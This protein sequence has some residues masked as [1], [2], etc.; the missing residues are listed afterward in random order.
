LN[1]SNGIT[2]CPQGFKEHQKYLMDECDDCSKP[3][4][5]TSIQIENGKEL[6]DTLHRIYT[7][8]SNTLTS[9]LEIGKLWKDIHEKN[10]WKSCGNEEVKT[11]RQFCEKECMRSHATVYNFINLFEKFSPHAEGVAVEQTR[12]VKALPFVTNEDTAKDWVSKAT[13]LNSEDYDSEIREARGK[14]PKDKCEH[15]EMEEYERCVSCGKWFK[16]GD[17]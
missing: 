9:V 16:V 15:E 5:E 1:D 4:S 3:C 11:F 10:L 13:T 2:N 17:E 7:L 14:I 8:E 12:L 6:Q